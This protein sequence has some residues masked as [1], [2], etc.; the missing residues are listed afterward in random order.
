MIR[1]KPGD[2]MMEKRLKRERNKLFLRVLLILLAVWL[3]VSA[4][5]CAVRLNVEEMNVQNSE[6]AKLSQF[7]KLVILENGSYDA[8]NNA[9]VDFSDFVYDKKAEQ[10]SFDS[11]LEI[12]NSATDEILVNTARS[13]GLQFAVMISADN[14]GIVIGMLDRNR[15]LKALSEEQLTEITRYLTMQRDDGDQYE[16]VCTRSQIVNLYIIPVEL[17]IMLV[18]GRDSRF[19]VDSNVAVYDLKS[20][21]EPDQPVYDSSESSRNTIPKD[22]LLVE[23]YGKDYLGTL[24]PKQLHQSVGIERTGLWDFLFYTSDYLHYDDPELYAQTD[25]WLIHYAKHF[26]VLHNC[27]S[28]L[29]LG[30]SLMFGFFLTIAVILCV[31]IWRT[32]KTQIIQEQKRLDLTNALAHD[33]KTPLFVI[34]GYAYSL[35][36][37]IDEAERDSY[38]D[39]IIG[40]T[41]AVNDLV[42]RMLNY[43]KLDSYNM[44]LSKQELDL[45]ELTR[46]ILKN[47]TALPDSRTISFTESGNNTV[48]ADR[49]LITTALQNL[50]DNAAKYSLPDSEIEIAV[51]D[52]TFVISNRSEPLTPEELK[53]LREPYFRKDKSRHRKGNGLGL[54]IVTSILGMHGARFEMKM[55]NDVLTCRIKF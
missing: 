50:I 55:K 6:L 44:T 15:L 30:V 13:I 34:S 22:F 46:E 48:S 37:N 12:T 38:L 49:E 19:T 2:D 24:T 42:H 45:G 43:S 10:H 16:L 21:S 11:Q 28:D 39:A 18:D 32:V 47:Y 26:N 33:I 23:A 14:T 41:E 4:V 9:F 36:E 29:T 35:K 40:Q 3:A 20:N 25:V 7:K 54:S 8:F 1:I 17:K 52:K 5:F 51:I 31:M 27:R 53:Q